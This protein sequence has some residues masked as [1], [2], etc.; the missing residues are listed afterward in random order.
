MDLTQFGWGT[1]LGLMVLATAVRYFIFTGST[2]LYFH[3]K[4][5]IRFAHRR[6][7][8]RATESK[9]I[10]R[11]IKLSLQTIL[12]FSISGVFIVTAKKMGISQVYTDV[13]KYGLAWAILSVPAMLILHDTYF[14]WTHRAMHESKWLFKHM[15]RDHHLS[16]H[17]SPFTAFAFHPSEALVQTGIAILISLFLPVHQLSFMIFMI[18]T[19]SMNVLG[20]LGYELYPSWFMNTPL[21][22]ILNT[23][24][25]H[26]LHHQKSKANYSLYFNFWD[27]IMGTN[28]RNYEAIYR[29]TTSRP[30]QLESKDGKLVAESA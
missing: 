2:Y 14:Y 3:R 23:T 5:P 6:L 15:H 27:R 29:E 4:T 12:I 1:L 28:Y 22:Y 18:I 11:E 16:H 13:D 10:R 8:P 20:H 24:T 17:P 19:L 7:N 26:H 30:S 9:Q 21:K 25:H